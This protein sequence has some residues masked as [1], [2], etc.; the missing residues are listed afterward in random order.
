MK[1]RRFIKTTTALVVGAAVSP[2]AAC[3]SEAKKAFDSMAEQST[4]ASTQF[5]LP[6]LNYAFDALAPNIDAKT[7]EIHHDKHHAGYVRKFNTALEG[8]THA[9]KSLEDILAGIGPDDTGLRN[10]GGG[11]YNH[12]LFW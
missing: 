4:E 10:N 6:A 2:M 11:H 8:S 1:K 3:K 12:S 7:M 5:E 9:G